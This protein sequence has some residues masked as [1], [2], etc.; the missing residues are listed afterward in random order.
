[1]A[2]NQVTPGSGLTTAGYKL[3]INT[4]ANKCYV[5]WL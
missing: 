3:I 1:M 2:Q 5:K 4:V